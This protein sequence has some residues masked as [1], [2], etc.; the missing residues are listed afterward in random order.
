MFF[1]PFLS[2][3]KSITQ[4]QRRLARQFMF[5][6]TSQHETQFVSFPADCGLYAKKQE[7]RGS[8]GI[9]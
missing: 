1:S 3:T 5:R 9:W 4:Q 8:V 2:N 6:Q 7:G